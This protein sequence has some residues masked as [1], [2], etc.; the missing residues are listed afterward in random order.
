ML[1]G[2]EKLRQLEGMIFGDESVGKEPKPI[3]KSKTDGKKK[4]KKQKRTPSKGQPAT[5]NKV[6]K[7]KSIFFTLL[8]WKDNLLRH[9]LNVMHVEKNVMDNILGTLLNIKGKTKDNLETHKDLQEMG[10]IP[11]LHPFTKENGIIYMLLSCH[12]MALED[13]TNFLK[14]F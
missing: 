9:N 1:G 8:Y 5:N 6:W 7:K 12:M 13:K 3:A 14:V 11:M 2:V 10:L 4:E